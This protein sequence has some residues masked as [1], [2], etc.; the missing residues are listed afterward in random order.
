MKEYNVNKPLVQGEIGIGCRN[1]YSFCVPSPDA[2]FFQYQ[3]DMLVRVAVRIASED[4]KGFSW[5]QI[6]G[7]GWRNQGLLDADNNPRPAYDAYQQLILQLDDAKYLTPVNYGND[8]EAYAFQKTSNN[9]HVIWTKVD[10]SVDI[11]VP[12]SKF[13]DA[14]DRDGKQISNPP[15]DGNNYKITAGFSP[16]YIIRKP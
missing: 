8:V 14:F 9:V 10:K 12:I 4:I 2:K 11:L 7:N 16:I 3:A 5:Y 15:V 1:D 13:I 6:N